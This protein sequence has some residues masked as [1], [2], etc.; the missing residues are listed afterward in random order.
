MILILVFAIKQLVLLKTD[1]PLAIN[2][3]PN[4]SSNFIQIES[5]LAEI[6]ISIYNTLG[7]QVSNLIWTGASIDISQLKKGFY[8]W[9]LSAKGI[10]FAPKIFIKQ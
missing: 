4:P 8:F 1:I 2:I 6:K 3:F 10:Q 9:E 5:E 7:Q